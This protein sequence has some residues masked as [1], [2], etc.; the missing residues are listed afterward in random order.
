MRVVGGMLTKIPISTNV[1]LITVIYY[2]I[3]VK[4]YFNIIG[5]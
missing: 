4:L 3:T 5:G 2:L 1:H